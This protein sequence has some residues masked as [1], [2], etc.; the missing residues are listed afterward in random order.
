[1]KKQQNN[2]LAKQAILV[3]VCAGALYFILGAIAFPTVVK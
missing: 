1:M 3:F 2:E